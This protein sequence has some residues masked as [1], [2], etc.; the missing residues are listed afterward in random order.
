MRH[1]LYSKHSNERD[2]RYCIRTDLEEDGNGKKVIV[3]YPLTEEACGHLEKMARSYERQCLVFGGTKIHPNVC[4][5]INDGEGHLK[6][7]EFEYL[8]GPTLEDELSTCVNEGRVDDGIMVIRNFC[9]TLRHLAEDRSFEM[10]DDFRKIFGNEE[11]PE[12]MTSL[13]ITDIDLIFTNF[14]M[15]GGWN[16]IDYEWTFD[17][18]VPIDFVI[19]RAIFYYTAKLA[20]GSYDGVDLFG[21]AGISEEERAVFGR[22]EHSFQLHIAGDRISLDGMY[23]IMGGNNIRLDRVV[24]AARLMER[25]EHVKLYYDYGRGFGEKDIMFIDASMNEECRV[26][27]DARVPEGCQALRVD[28]ANYRCIVKLYLIENGIEAPQIDVN[29]YVMGDNTVV[30]DTDDPQIVIGK[31]LPGMTVHVEY[32]IQTLNEQMFDDI[33]SVLSGIKNGAGFGM[34]KVFQ[35][36]TYTR[37]RL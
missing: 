8:T 15:D 31:V 30:Y 12:G 24:N 2:L 18:P 25:P 27:F 5:R 13:L 11:M 26:S 16:V 34:K 20:P 28:P 22:M 23:S 4:K 7:L 32:V 29:G 36:G 14:I 33:T 1:P 9:D 35:K 21:V 10:T 6:K 3:K 37:I 19:Y 17:F